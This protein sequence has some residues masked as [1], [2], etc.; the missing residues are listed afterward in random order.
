MLSGPRGTLALWSLWL[1]LSAAGCIPT[2][3]AR[4]AAVAYTAEDVLRAA[5]K[6]PDPA[7]VR[8]GS[9]AY[10]MLVDGLIEAYPNNSE[11]LTAGCQSYTVYASSFVEDSDPG[12]AAILYG[13]AKKYGF[14]A[15]SLRR[16]FRQAASGNF[17]HFTAFLKQYEKEE[18]PA[19]FCTSSAWAKWI[20]LNLD[21]VEALADVPMLKATLQRVIEL[22][23]GFYYGSPHLQMAV[24]LA[25]I[26]SIAGG[27]L[28]KAKE[29]F[30]EAFALGADKLLSAKV[31]FA[32]Y[33]A[34]RLKDR[35]LFEKTLKE[36][37]EAPLDE[38]PELTLSNTLAKEKA[39]ELL[40]RADEYFWLS[41]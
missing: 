4:V 25:A 7:I 31:L 15:L 16:D 24:Y 6:Q 23:G 14:R 18:V 30:D 26:P 12:K 35:A 32:R 41:P 9:P 37:M 1:L 10:I 29:H 13:K 38:V 19:L 3:Q 2:K 39:R 17:D 8:D 34:V 36:V 27:N 33:Y 20:G 40:E 28:E 22:D 5:A 11:L 21:R